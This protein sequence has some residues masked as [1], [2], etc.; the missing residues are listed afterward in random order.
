M[1]KL[2]KALL[3]CLLLCSSNQLIGQGNKVTGTVTG[4]EDGTPLIG[5]TILS[6][7]GTG[8]VSD[9]DGNFSLIVSA[10]ETLQFSYIGY[11]SQSINV[12]NRSTIDVVLEQDLQQLE[13]IVVT[14]LGIERDKKALGYSITEVGSENIARNGEINAINS[15]AGKVAGINI[16]TTTAGPSGSSRVIIRGISEIDGNNQPLYVIDGVPVDNGTL[17]QANQ[18]G[19]FDLGDGLSDIN[20]DDVESISVL[21]GASA[22]ALYG[23]RALNGV[24]LV[25]TKKGS[26]AGKGWSVDFNSTVT[27]D[28]ISTKLDE[29]QEIYGQGS[30]GIP[31]ET[32]DRARNITSN[33]GGQ[34]DPSVTV[35]QVDGTDRP[36]GL[37]KNNIQDLFEDGVT[38]NNTIALSGGSQDANIRMSFTDIDNSDILPNASLE[39]QNATLRAYSKLGKY[40]EID[41]KLSYIT[42]KVNNRPALTDEV[43]NIGNGVIGLAMNF[44][45]EWLQTYKNDDGTYLDYTG[46]IYRA[47]PYWTI[48]E[49]SNRSSKDRIMGF[50]SVKVNF[51]DWL[52][53]KLRSG[54]DYYTFKHHEFYNQHTPTKEAGQMVDLTTTLKETNSDFLLTANRNIN[55]D[56]RISASAGGNLMY[57]RSESLRLTGTGIKDP[58][59]G[60]KMANFAEVQVTPPFSPRKKINSLYGFVN[61]AFKE[62]LY[63]DITG[64]NDWYSTLHPDHNSLFYPSISTSFVLSDA[65]DLNIEALSF[66]KF[67]ASYAKVGGDADP[68]RRFN[69]YSYL[70]YNHNGMPLAE[71]SGLSQNNSELRPEQTRSLEFGADV[72]FFNGRIGL[73]AAYYTQTTD[74]LIFNAE[75]PVAGGYNFVYI[76]AGELKN[77]GVEL[78]LNTTPIKTASGLQWDLS[79]NF[80][81]NTTTVTRLTEDIKAITIA[82]ARW[83]G[84]KIVAEE[85][86]EFGLIT[87][88]AFLRDDQGNIIHGTDGMPR[89]TDEPVELGSTLPDWTAGAI[90]TLSYKGLS[91]KAAFD[92]RMGGDIF[93]V[94][95]MTMYGS[96][97]HPET[98]EGREGWNDYAQRNRDALDAWEAAGNAPEDFVNLPTDG[99]L[100]G[101]G[102]KETS[103]STED[104]PEYEANDQI[105]NPSDY[106]N[107]VASNAPEKFIYDAS[108]IKLRDLSLAY[109]LPRSLLEKTPFTNVRLSVIGRNLWTIYKNVPNIDPESTYNNGNGQ[110]LEYGSLPTRRHYGFSVNVSF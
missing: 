45:Q 61:F 72:R 106:W 49:T 9:I 12:G 96:G 101:P 110:G 33:W 22:A 104:N 68:Y 51:T 52:S 30:N 57:N 13:E 35:T 85:G 23:A 37:I 100:I 56:I 7:S 44:D 108:Y 21:K 36:Y 64:R 43:T 103:A 19:G 95:N 1:N 90:S 109:S 17:G 11:L 80:A 86:S 55:D 93:A 99:G 69:N 60:D 48:N 79:L 73:D 4:A 88:R 102:V 74:D 29:R 66:V 42:E 5:V 87:G 59:E 89:L 31:P 91:L 26:K 16:S 6:S 75:I 82:D 63:V 84:V 54:I 15:L 10:D 105:V 46:N 28:R 76:N 94:T 83:A 71:I 81:K 78:L 32:I 98:L 3:A 77:E 50:G 58:L 65:M 18:N 2:Y 40:F 97:A 25:T 38:Y 70:P 20:P 62:Y 34:F 14:A 8:T 27:L 92:V 67:R 24:I 41:G 53:L 47:N 107:F 39:R